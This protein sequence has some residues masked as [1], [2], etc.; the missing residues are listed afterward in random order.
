MSGETQAR[1]APIP[2]AWSVR[3]GRD[4]YLAENGFTLEA[5]DARWTKATIFGVP[6]V[7]PNTKRHRWAIMLHDLHHVA[8]GYGTDMAGEGEISG[9]ELGRGLGSLGLYVGSI[10]LFGAI[11]GLV[12]APRRTWAAFRASAAARRSLFHAEEPYEQ[13][14]EGDVG[15]LRSR[16][17]IPREG[18]AAAPRALHARAPARP[19]TA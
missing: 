18:L 1:E 4:A 11:G 12:V 8:T 15:A 2:A 16:L 3:R 13:L 9:W 5:Y 6:V 7:V 14:L 17:G 19:T 10:V